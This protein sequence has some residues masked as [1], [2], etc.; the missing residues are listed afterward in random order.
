MSDINTVNDQLV[1]VQGEHIV[2]GAPKTRMTR[3]EALRQ[4][5]WLVALAED[6]P[7]QFDV[8]LEAVMNT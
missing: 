4:A 1:G 6:G 5:A 2:V 7:D 8:I 3:A